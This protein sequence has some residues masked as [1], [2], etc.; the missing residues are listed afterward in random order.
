[1]E[2]V[3]KRYRNKHRN[4]DNN[5]VTVLDNKESR[6]RPSLI[7]KIHNPCLKISN[8][9][10]KHVHNVTANNNPHNILNASQHIRIINTNIL[11]K[12]SNFK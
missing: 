1:M 12:S 4:I 8:N 2:D 9:P 11:V 10:N 7:P 6:L 5:N 3:C